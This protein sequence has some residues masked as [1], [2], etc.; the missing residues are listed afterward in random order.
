MAEIINLNNENF[1][2]Q[3]MEE[4]LP[5]LVDFTASWCG[6]CQMMTPVLENLATEYEGRL[7][8]A[9]VNVDD[10]AELSAQYGIM[11]VPTLIL[12]KEGK[13]V[14]TLVG[15]QPK[16]KLASRLDALI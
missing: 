16:N 5:V 7:K 1:K 11:G 2:E 9:K 6:P 10:N 3:V 12:F 13:Q 8:I 4:T 15:F 14:E